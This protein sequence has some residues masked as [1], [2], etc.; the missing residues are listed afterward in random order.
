MSRDE[1]FHGKL[2]LYFTSHATAVFRDEIDAATAPGFSL[3]MEIF[4]RG[5]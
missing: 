2:K 3:G 1:K 5:Y 4:A